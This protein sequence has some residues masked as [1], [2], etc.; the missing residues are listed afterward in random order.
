ML[1]D[2]DFHLF[3]EGAVVIQIWALLTRSQCKVSNTQ[4]T[5]KACGPL[6]KIT[7]IFVLINVNAKSIS[8]CSS[9]MIFLDLLSLFNVYLDPCPCRLLI[10]WLIDWLI[11]PLSLIDWLDIVLSLV[12]YSL[13]DW[14]VFYPLSFMKYSMFSRFALENSL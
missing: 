9:Y 6:V 1:R 10:D 4:V 13:I 12:V 11:Y 2:Y 14:I 3:Y 8:S 7:V 5:D